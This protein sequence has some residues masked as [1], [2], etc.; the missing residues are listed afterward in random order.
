MELAFREL[1]VFTGK[2]AR[3]AVNQ[4]LKVIRA[5]AVLLVMDGTKQGLQLLV[6][7]PPLF[8]GGVQ[9]LNG[10]VTGEGLA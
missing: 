5:E 1:A 9:V 3:R 8:N 10:S 6:C 2:L 4:L 7:N